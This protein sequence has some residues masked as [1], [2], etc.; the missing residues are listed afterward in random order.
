MRQAEQVAQSLQQ[1]Q[2]PDTTPFDYIVVGSGAGGGPLAARLALGGQRVL[3]IEAGVD[4]ISDNEHS[5]AHRVPIYN[6]AATE[7][8]VTSWAFSVRQYE[9]DER[10]KRSTKYC[11]RDDP[12]QSGGKG[13]IFYPRAAALGGCT[14]H[15][16]MVFV[17]PNDSDWDSLADLTGDDSWRSE[18]MQ[19]YFP[20]LERCLYYQVYKGFFGRL[21]G[22]I[23]W[24][25]QW[26]ATLIAPR[27][28]LDPNGH[29]SRGW[30]PTS[31]IDPL[32][33]VGIARRDFILLRLLWDVLWASLKSKVERRILWRALVR[34]QIVQFLDP[35]VRANYARFLEYRARLC[36]IPIGTDGSER[37]GLRE[38]LLKV[39]GMHPDRLV[40]LTGAHATRLVFDRDKD[41]A[42]PRAIGV[43][44]LRGAH[45]YRASPKSGSAISQGTEQY[46][47][48]REVI[49]SGGAFNSPQ[50]L[51]LSGIGDVGQLQSLGIRSLRNARG[52]KIAAP[53]NLPGVGRN[54][55]DRYEVS[56]ITKM[57]KEFATLKGATFI[58]GDKNDPHRAQWLRDRTGLYTIN[59]SALA[60]L[61][62]SSRNQNLPNPDHLVLGVPAAFRGYYHGWS[63]QLLKR[64]IGAGEDERK[65]WS[66]VVLKA[67]T[68]NNLGTVTLRTANALDVPEINFHSF[69]ESPEKGINDR[70]AIADVIKRLREINGEIKGIAEE[71]QPGPKKGND[72]R[73]LREWIEDEAWG[74]HACGTCKIGA[75]RWQ[76][77][78]ANLTD[79]RAVVDSAFRVHGVRGLR[80]VDASVFPRIPGY[81][82]VVPTFMIAEKAADVILAD[83]KAYP[84]KVECRESAAIQARR[85]VVKPS[86]NPPTE[87]ATT[88][89]EDCIGLALSGG[90]IRS[91]TYSLG[92]L[93]GL[94]ATGMLRRIDFMSTVSG[95][96]FA[97]AFLGRLFTRLKCYGGDKFAKV[98]AILKDVNAPEIWW[99]RRHADYLAGAGLSD[100]ETSLAV[101][102]R[103]LVSVFFCIG[104][105]FFG[106][107][108]G[109]RLIADCALPAVPGS[110]TI[111]GVPLSPW[112]WI[113][114][115][116]LALGVLP[117]CIGY[118]LTPSGRRRSQYAPLGL[119]AWSA[120]LIAAITAVSV[121]GLGWWG[122]LV[123][124]ILVLAWL[125][126]EAVRWGTPSEQPIVKAAWTRSSGWGRQQQDRAVGLATLYRNRL[127]RTLGSFLFLLAAAIAFVLIDTFARTAFSI[128]IAPMIGGLLLAV[129]SFLPFAR[130]VAMILLPKDAPPVSPLRAMA[131]KALLAVVVFV[132]A[133]ALFF[134]IDAIAHAAIDA[135]HGIGIW[136]VA[137]ALGCSV[138]FGRAINF[139]NLSS[140]QQQLTQQLARTF[141]GASNDRRVHPVGATSPV[142]VQVPDE[143]DD[144][145]F[146]NYHP[147]KSGGPL[148]LVSVCVNQTVDHISGRQLRQ[149][150]GLP[151][152][153]GP[154]GLSVGRQYHALW[155]RNADPSGQWAEVRALPVAPDPNAFHV[156]AR[157]DS[158]TASVEQL[159]LGRWIAISAASLSTGAGRTGSLP[160]SLLLG[161]FNF[162]LGYWW[163]SGIP[164][165]RRPSRYP[166]NLWRRIKSLP[167]VIFATQAMI[168]EEWR[169]YFEGPSA[170]RWYLSDGGHFDNTGLYELI[171]RRLPF[172]VAVDAGQDR[173]YRFDDLSILE[174]QVRLDF[175]ARIDWLDP[176]PAPGA[177]IS[178][179]V[180]GTAIP[181]WITALI[182][183]PERLGRLDQTKRNGSVVGALARITY[184]D[185]SEK[186]SWLLLVKANLAPAVPADV[187]NYAV[188]HPDFPNESTIDQFFGDDQWESYRSL[189]E[190]AAR[191]L[192]GR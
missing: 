39:R 113:P 99:L 80:V 76:E 120:L 47:A 168:L 78:V 124:G 64:T 53:I 15:H 3:V 38:W 156:L 17:R 171:R 158:E 100:L 136:A 60:L 106:V 142:P 56:V 52:H 98:E 4:P 11:L 166:P 148:H 58:P 97:G 119:L 102:I 129:T 140:L 70:E 132:L 71:I 137:A 62:S 88:L 42:S 75:D 121:A 63:Q 87:P 94:A 112:W 9:D 163:N 48:R 34:W 44:V 127:A 1:A 61:V 8:P 29:G 18:T 45:L 83:S 84:S 134:A 13:G 190:N 16:A 172:I 177:A 14:C 122:L 108:G 131:G 22:G 111:W 143:D 165:S 176:Q 41:R 186:V 154:V 155:E 24:L 185:D 146:G 7:D 55:Q 125:W 149:N 2:N 26:L 115:A 114:A 32:V 147:E 123:I 89:P 25:V 43:E 133:T 139:V 23:L 30:Q 59:G 138:A 187:T 20:R 157:T 69:S 151:M 126:Q 95:G 116:V 189:G 160:K 105:L 86:P 173:D 144:Q 65:F 82:I 5:E 164:A 85:E 181:N 180:F 79:N 40:L 153:V 118:W 35:N 175:N 6:A 135:G 67:Y 104:L 33:I 162:R 19:G 174:R 184:E 73:A 54:L 128:S 150:K 21:L 68:D 152:C 117:L 103:N 28:Q 130:R 57:H 101:L 141:L 179:R 81:F 12:A 77:D 91:A 66:W 27:F 159:S 92:V 72:S 145:S 109:L 96:G 90:G 31:F 170:R 46:F 37:S 50:L 74:H 10:Q 110:W 192:F 188:T 183:H 161:L 169:D 36:L 182:I 178:W 51:M 93:Q 107:L 167:S 191:S 49:V